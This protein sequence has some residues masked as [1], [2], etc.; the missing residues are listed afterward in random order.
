LVNLCAELFYVYLL[1]ES[2]SNS[3]TTC[4]INSFTVLSGLA[5]SEVDRN[6]I[7]ERLIHICLSLISIHQNPIFTTI[8]LIILYLL[9]FNHINTDMI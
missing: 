4:A 8:I 2:R 3:Q 5:F 9:V 1:A 7:K 6:Y